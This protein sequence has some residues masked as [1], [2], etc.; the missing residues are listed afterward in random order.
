MS[1][2]AYGQRFP[3]SSMCARPPIN[4]ASE[5]L[6]SETN[7][8]EPKQ[9]RQ[10]PIAEM[11]C[12]TLFW[13]NR[14][15]TW[16]DVHLFAKLF[17]WSDLSTRGFILR[18]TIIIITILAQQL[19]SGIGNCCYQ[20]GENDGMLENETKQREIK[21]EQLKRNESNRVDISNFMGSTRLRFVKS[22]RTDIQ[23]C[24][25]FFVM[26]EICCGT[27]V[28]SIFLGMAPAFSALWSEVVRG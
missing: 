3:E 16:F 13:N 19:L 15:S 28:P 9:K 7:Q 8:A 2:H 11:R 25:W 20:D 12:P 1:Q 4:S 22:G 21:Y 26:K 10:L 17:L 14:I 23:I 6:P 27:S 24:F 5:I 18:N